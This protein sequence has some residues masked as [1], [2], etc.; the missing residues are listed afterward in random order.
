MSEQI[1]QSYLSEYKL[2]REIYHD[3]MP[4]KIR[5][6]LLVS[7]LYDAYI[8]EQ[9]DML[10]E[11]IFGEYY[12][13]N[14][15]SAPKITSA[16]SGEEAM[17]MLNQKQYDLVILTM[18]IDEFSPF[19]YSQKIRNQYP[20]LPIVLLLND[21]SDIT[22][23]QQWCRENPEIDRI[24]VWSG[25]PKIFLAIIK[26][27]EDLKNVHHDT[28]VGMVRVILLVED[29]IRYYSRYLPLLYTEIIKQTQRLIKE[30]H[31]DESKKLLRMRTRPKILLCD[32]YS[33]AIKTLNNYQEYLAAVISDFKFPLHHE[34]REDAGIK[35]IREVKQL[36]PD[37]PVLMQSYDSEN[38]VHA[39]NLKSSFLDKNSEMLEAE[40]KNFIITNLGFGDFVFKDSR[41]NELVRAKNLPEFKALLET[42]TEDS[43]LFHGER[44]HFSSWLMAR[45]EIKIARKLQKSKVSDFD[46]V[47]QIREHLLKTC[48]EVEYEKTKG[49]I[50]NFDNRYIHD[51]INISR[52]AGGS[53]GGK[54]RG[55]AFLNNLI[56]HTSLLKNISG[57]EI[58]IP[59]TVIIGTEAFEQFIG[60]NH[61]L[62]FAAYEDDIFNLR[63]EFIKHPLP[64]S[65]IEKLKTYL[66]K[67]KYPLAVR[68]SGLFEDS[69]AQPFSGLYNTY[70]IPNHHPRL[71]QRLQ[72]LMD[73]VKLVYA[74]VY[75]KIARSYFD[76]VNYKIE[77]ERMAVII[78]EVAGK[79]YQNKFYPHI[80]GIAQSYNYYP[81]SHIKPEEGIAV[82][83]VGLGFY[84]VE[85][86]Q[87]Y[88][89]C[90]T[91]PKIEFE[92]PID[93]LSHTQ[94]KLIGLNLSDD[95]LD[96]LAGE[97]AA[98]TTIPLDRN[99]ELQDF[100]SCLST[101][102]ADNSRLVP[103][104]N[105]RGPLVVNFPYILKYQTF[106]L[107]EI[108]QKILDILKYA[109]GTPV[110]IEFAVD[111]CSRPLPLFFLLQVKPFMRKISELKIDL[112][113]INPEKVILKS[114]RSLGNG[115]IKNIL[116]VIY[117]E[118]EK[119]DKS[120]TQEIAKEIESFNDLAKQN[121]FNYLLIGPGRWGSRDQWLGIPVDW[122]QISR[123]KAIV[124]YGLEDFQ[125]DPSLG[126]HF[127]HNITSMNIGYLSIDYQGHKSFINWDWLKQH[128]P[129]NTGKYVTCLKLSTPLHILLQGR[130]GKGIIYY[131]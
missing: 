100:Q 92:T 129:Q 23:C 93:L 99:L 30:E 105:N 51:R 81:L 90:P 50:I 130:E 22:L 3:L 119:F 46:S 64:S 104:V 72:Q 126:S 76:A 5:D 43:L 71:D 102:D 25:E 10:T 83:A 38:R 84:V 73:A 108:I 131:N 91:H 59:N 65:L 107:A 48:R 128:H 18:R 15:S 56:H 75:S 117:I 116:Q 16:S 121:S 98:L 33:Q 111:L 14:L 77:E 82:I 12:Q 54:G 94:K 124:E 60:E 29:S 63:A 109:L 7:T 127:F 39:D 31:L 67:I 42:I 53:L 47:K 28:E 88:R 6:I 68:S 125:V 4:F 11:K 113:Q 110:E 45:G 57:A 122:N 114:N 101:W 8:I 32:N 9:E 69:L 115:E 27:I 87:A 52:L 112:N 49:K 36:L 86:G 17:Q 35:L 85:G 74:S 95:E 62:E 70:I 58:T 120:K 26:Y 13:L 34:I 97:Q 24:F 2:Q 37:L 41:G 61:L 55:I 66:E 19:E 20:Q 78:Q 89:F 118:P 21:H 44:N 103:G 1:Y 80:S 106:P 40:L 96:L 123:A 79:N